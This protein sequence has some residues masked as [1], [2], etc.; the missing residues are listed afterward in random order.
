MNKKMMKQVLS[1][2]FAMR[3][4]EAERLASSDFGPE[5]FWKVD[6]EVNQV[7]NVT[8][9]E[10]GIAVIHVDGPLSYRSDLW[11]AIFGMDTYDSIRESFEKC[12]ADESVKGIIFDINSPGGEVGGCADL[13][14]KIFKARGSKEYGIVARTGGIMCSAAYWIGSAC[15]KVYTA[16]NGTLGSIGVLCAFT[17]NKSSMDVVVSDLSP[18]K[19]P[20]PDTPDGL[21]LIKKELNDLAEVFINAVAKNRGTTAEDVKENFGKGGVFIGQKAV[22]AHL[23][24]G[25]ASIE[26]VCE[27]MSKEVIM[28]NEEIKAA[29]VAEYKESISA[30]KAIFED[31]GIS[32]DPIAFVDSGKTV[33]DAKDF[34]FEAMKSERAASAEANA[35]ALAEKDAEI[36]ALKEEHEKALAAKDEEIEKAK[37]EGVLSEE[38]KKLIQK[39]LEAQAAEQNGVHG[40][41]SDSNPDRERFL[42]A[43]KR[44]AEARKG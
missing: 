15:E 23:A 18:D 33:A 7:N 10:D 44:A 21:A 8:I 22:D 1:T 36:V 13:A 26:E 17:K 6:G 5:G 19:A 3:N 34:A 2:R 4:D 31:C 29:A 27:M 16:S 9:R 28:T 30:V 40:G 39:G 25:V 11:T 38:Q 42:A 14:E 32:D 37:A 20:T 43:Y 24:D 41:A 12:L 35:K